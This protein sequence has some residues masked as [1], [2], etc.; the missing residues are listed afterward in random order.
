[1]DQ[2]HTSTFQTASDFSLVAGSFPER[3]SVS[4][5]NSLTLFANIKRL[6]RP[7]VLSPR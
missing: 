7:Y 2:K 5:E 6:L 1:M 3:R 4:V